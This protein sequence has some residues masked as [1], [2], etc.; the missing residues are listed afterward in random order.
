MQSFASKNPQPKHDPYKSDVYSLGMTLLYA[1]NL[2][3]PERAYR[4]TGTGVG[5]DENGVKAEL[6]KLAQNYSKTLHDT[7]EKMLRVNENERPDFNALR[8]LITPI[9]SQV[10]EGKSPDQLHYD[11]KQP[12]NLTLISY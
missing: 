10:D 2:Q 6:A 7:I 9:K 3:N 12:K 8:S 11:V 4:W 5:I 1:A